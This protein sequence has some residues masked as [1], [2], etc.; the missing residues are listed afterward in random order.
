MLVLLHINYTVFEAKTYYFQVLSVKYSKQKTKTMFILY[1][2]K[3]ENI[4]LVNFIKH[5]NF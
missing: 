1:T 2:N 3:I 4:L 5:F